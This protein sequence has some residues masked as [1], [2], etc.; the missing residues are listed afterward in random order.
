MKTSVKG[1]GIEYNF[2]RSRNSNLCL[3]SKEIFQDHVSGFPWNNTV[4]CSLPGQDSGFAF[5]RVA[6]TASVAAL[7]QVGISITE[8]EYQTP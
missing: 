8:Q 3:I 1:R 7:S 4:S 2:N 6:L 5:I